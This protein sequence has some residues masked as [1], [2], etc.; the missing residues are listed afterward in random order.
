RTCGGHGNRR[1][2]GD[3]F[4]FTRPVT[5]DYSGAFGAGG[6]SGFSLC[7]LTGNG[8]SIVAAGRH[9]KRCVRAFV[10]TLIL[11][12]LPAVIP[13]PSQKVAFGGT[14]RVKDRQRRSSGSP[15]STLRS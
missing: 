1:R 4:A 12:A 11:T 8:S 14:F 9:V 5:W 6:F 3:V 15:E 10:S 13:V 2:I 7:W